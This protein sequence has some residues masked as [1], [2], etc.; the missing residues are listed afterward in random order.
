MAPEIFISRLREIGRMLNRW[1]AEVWMLFGAAVILTVLW[2]LALSDIALGY[3]RAGRMVAWGLPVLLLAALL[4]RIVRVASRAH[5]PESVAVCVE[6][7]FPQLDNHLINFL[8][9]AAAGS[10]D[11]FKTAY[12]KMGVPLWNGL[13]FRAMK[14]R[15]LHRRA[16]LALGAAV[17]LFLIPWPLIGN[18]W[19]VAVWRIVNPFS[20]IAPVSMTR[21]LEVSPGNTSVVQG[22]NMVLSCRVQGKKGHAVQ[23]DLKPADGGSKTVSL[24]ALRGGEVEGFS[25]TLSKVTTDMKYRFRAGDAYVDGWYELIVR[26]PLAFASVE[27]EVT[28]PAYTGLRPRRYDAQ[29]ASMEFPVGSTVA[30]KARVNTPATGLSLAVGGEPAALRDRDGGLEWQGT[31]VV[32][33]GAAF[34]LTATAAEG[35]RAEATLGFTLSPDRP[36]SLEIKY[37]R[38]PVVLAPGAAPTIEFAAND[39]FGLDEIT[40]ERLPE[41]SA[42]KGTTNVVKSFK[43]I[44]TRNKEYSALWKGDV[45]KTLEKATLLFRVVARDNRLPDR[46]ETVSAVLSFSTG[47]LEA[48]SRKQAEGERRAI[49]D[50]NRVIDMQR[51]NVDRTRQY[52]GQLATT[53]SDLWAAVAERQQ[54]IRD[55]VKVL[56]EKEGGKYLGALLG[57]VRKLFAGE[58]TEVI[59][60]LRAIPGAKEDAGRTQFVSRA[61][62]L[63]EK[64]LRQLTFAG[65]AAEQARIDSRNSALT[66]LLDGMIVRQ[67]KLIKGALRCVSQDVAVAEA[68]V[69]E[70]DALGSDVSAFMKACE[71]EAAAMQGDDPD[72]AAFLRG[73]AAY[74]GEQKLREDMLKAAEFMEK[75]ELR[76]ALRTQRSAYDKLLTARRKFDELK[77]LAEKEQNETLI[78]ALE[79]AR[80]KLEKLKAL[81]KKLIEEMDL[82]EAQRDKSGKQTDRMEEDFKELQENLKDA[83]LQIPRD[84]DIFAHLNVGNDLVEDVYSVFEEV[85]QQEPAGPG[86]S[87]PVKEIAQIKRE[88]LLDG[89]DRVKK[90]LDDFESWLKNVADGKKQLAEAFDKEEMPEGVALTPL[91]T[92]MDDIIGDLMKED[93]KQQQEDQ[94]GAINS[95]VP[96]LEMGGAIAEGNLTAFS[97]KGRSGNERPDHKEQDGRSNV[98]RQGMANGETAAGSGTIGKGDD[99]IEARRTQDP[100]QAG[101]VKADGEASTKAT[102]GGKLGSGKGDG[103]GQGQGITRMDSSEAGSLEGLMAAMAKR[104]DSAYAQASLKGLRADSLKTAAHHIRQANDAIAKGAPIAQVQE[105][106]RKAIMDLRKAKTELGQGAVSSL[107]AAG[108]G[109]LIHDVVE[110]SPDEAPPRYRGLVS[111]YYKKLSESL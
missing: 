106:K 74:C 33:H 21:L 27:L 11:P 96:D 7:A 65:K 56:L 66:G 73:I 103:Y 47:E 52:Q 1:S 44:V 68:Q 108:T 13:D 70:Q 63:E 37:P 81:E 40:I 43:W 109:E 99:N 84:L 102:G 83:L 54:A 36:P 5:T 78:E 20:G 60:L 94:D 71:A 90:R 9:F 111:E 64:I 50:L 59:P 92:E 38:Q 24:G 49:A 51:E 98:G 25:H 32:T 58:M 14:D 93:E 100:T 110:S 62:A 19:P 34:V 45:P 57:A 55:E 29:A 4:S 72:F 46:N 61:L 67:D 42:P 107:D 10:G 86:K 85:T 30:V 16:Q 18:A 82:V 22:R 48:A 35:E 101:Q 41:P 2:G 87:G 3:H 6:R 77:A 104:A 12:V 91:Q 26:P 39:D 88:Q 79:G 28:P 105:L 80:E 8:Q 23:L 75:Q 89:M 31:V 53:Q 95:A 15:R 97:A 17:L 69:D 76:E